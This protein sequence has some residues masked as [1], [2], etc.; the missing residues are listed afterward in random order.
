[1]AYEILD[2]ATYSSELLPVGIGHVVMRA[3]DV[4]L[5]MSMVPANIG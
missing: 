1:M 4:G 2:T 3:T 5:P